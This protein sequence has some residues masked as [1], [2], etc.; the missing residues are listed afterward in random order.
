MLNLLSNPIVMLVLGVILALLVV[1]FINIILP[2]LDK[3]HIDVSGNLEK[4]E[5][6]IDTVNVVADTANS[7]LPGNPAVLGLKVVAEW[8]KKA[9]GEAEQ[10]YISSKLDKDGRNA[11]AKETVYAAL[12]VANVEL[13]PELEKAIDGAIEFETNALGHKDDA[14]KIVQGQLQQTNVQLQDQVVSQ[15]Q[16]IQELQSTNFSLTKKLNDIQSAV[17]TAAQ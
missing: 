3:N 16:Q 4:A 6:V 10:L 2:K 17:Q 8:A 13:T 12:K 1:Y 7:I 15:N 5:K 9:V 14:T 11:K